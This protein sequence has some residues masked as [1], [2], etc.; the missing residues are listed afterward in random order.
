[1]S[2][3]KAKTKK[4]LVWSAFERFGTQGVQFLFSLLL[5]RLLAPEDY[6]I[7]A[8]PMIFLG[9]AQVFIDSGFANALVRKP[10][11]TEN[12]LST[13]FWFN[14]FVGLV[15]YVVL[16]ISSSAIASFYDTPIL[17]P[18]LKITALSTLFNPL[19]TV[20]QAILTRSIDF[21]KQ[22]H[23]SIVGAI[24]GGC[25]GVFLAYNNYGVW[26]LALS[27]CLSSL[28]RVVM[29]WII[30]KWKPILSWSSDSFKYLWGFGSK[31]MFSGILETLYQN[32]Y[33]LVIGKVYSSSS[34]GYY[35][36]AQHFAQFP[37]L[38]IYG[39][40]RRVTLP[41]LSSIQSDETKTIRVF[42]KI[43]RVTVFIIFPLMFFL[44]AISE[45]MIKILL[46][47]KWIQT[48]PILQVL[49]FAMMSIPVDALNL[50]LLTVKGRSDLF[51]R[52]EIIK[53]IIGLAI[54][55]IAIKYGIIVLCSGYALYCVI[56]IVTD[57]YY[58]G[59]FYNLGFYAQIK[60]I[61]PSFLLSLVALGLVHTVNRFIG[62][63][64]LQICFAV[65][66]FTV[67]IIGTS[68]VFRLKEYEDLMF[69]LKNNHE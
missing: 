68:K 4:G 54:L 55:I 44:I 12:D 56:E 36:R 35:T 40:L 11:L 41:V 7:I 51:L 39:I 28:Y 14:V 31:L 25:F 60:L 19:C 49:S 46:T 1:M 58:S 24:L 2:N 30:T 61:Y 52:L 6:G 17:A 22:A 23:V 64:F 38:N 62:N 8:M 20:Q 65:I 66:A 50:S 53:K 29:L 67:I 15:C 26:A 9:L 69:F 13:A 16:F 47:D 63:D 18:I 21:K 43:L 5:A 27:Q 59:K 34:L 10:N 32:M 42:E 3:L 57:T 48:V 37:S 45:P 33:T